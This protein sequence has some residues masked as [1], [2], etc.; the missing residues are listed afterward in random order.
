MTEQKFANLYTVVRSL[1]E[2]AKTTAVEN[3]RRFIKNSS[4]RNTPWW[5][6]ALGVIISLFFLYYPLGGLLVH[7]IDTSSAYQPK[8]AENK[9]A[10]VDMM[11]HLINREVHYKI[12]TP[13][14]PFMFPS[15]FLDNMPNFQLGLMSAIAKT[16]DALNKLTFTSASASAADNLSDAAEL[17]QYPGNIWLFSPQNK[18]LP[19]PSANT[20][21]K[22]GRKKLNNFNNEISAGKILLPRNTQNLSL[23]LQFIKKDISRLVAKTEDHIRENSDSFTDFKADDTFYFALG[24]LYAYSQII[25]SLGYDFKDVLVSRDVY[26]QWTAA[27]R[28]LQ[29]ASDLNPAIVRNG[30]LNSS[31]APNHLVTINYLASRTVNRLNTII[32]KLNQ[33]VDMQ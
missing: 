23:I 1:A 18:L 31:F 10:S 15:Y 4:A 22:K 25:K 21:Y 24:K 19:V 29:E 13:N 26:Q 33:P 12:W 14:L 30:S 11:S 7:N 3:S 17:L 28:F 20:Q 9:L 2:K 6:I 8:T 5:Q 32:N 27:L 16:T